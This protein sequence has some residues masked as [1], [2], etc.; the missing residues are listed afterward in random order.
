[1]IVDHATPVCQS[2]NDATEPLEA[3]ATPTV[4]GTPSDN[5]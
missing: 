3:S 5:A 2:P 1:L 4:A